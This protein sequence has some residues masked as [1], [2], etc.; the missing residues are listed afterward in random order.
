VKVVVTGAHGFLGW[1]TCARLRAL[2]QHDVVRVGRNEWNRLPELVGAAD[3]VIHLAGV[4]RGDVDLETANVQLGRELAAALRSTTGTRVLV[5]AGTIHEGPDTP[6]GRGKAAAGELLR[7][8]A[9]EMR[10]EFV[11]VRLP[12]IF[13]EHGRAG[14]N[15]FVATFADAVAR[16]QHPEVDDRPIE[17]LHAQKA[18]D[19]M[20]EALDG[21]RGSSVRPVGVQT[22]VAQVLERLE[23]IHGLYTVKAELPDLSDDFTLDL[24][25]TYRARLFPLGYPIPLVGHNDARG[26]LVETVR[27]HGGQGQT[28]VSTTVPG[29]T[30]G[31]HFHL[32]KVERFVVV[33]GD[34]VIRLRRVL[35]DDVLEFAVSGDSPAVIDMPTMWVHNITNIG[36]RPLTTLFWTESLFD[37]DAPDTYREQVAR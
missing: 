14:Y 15:S 18:A 29:A 24:F 8:V 11:H 22:S 20:I 21:S 17:L 19:A 2:T 10:T 32:R 1:H 30:R 4:N 12:N 3:A 35:H 31:D 37:A 33:D 7:A 27:S 34:A 5:Y 36:S 26:R 28:F 9:S 13:G 6:Y 25:N 16:G 23:K